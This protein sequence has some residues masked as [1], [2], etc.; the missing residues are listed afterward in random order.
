MTNQ[1][2]SKLLT[3]TTK[4]IVTHLPL[5]IF[6][7]KIN[8]SFHIEVNNVWK[9]DLLTLTLLFLSEDELMGQSFRLAVAAS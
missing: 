3:S 4:E 9:M 1:Q 5:S 6:S 8:Y 2:S 7:Q